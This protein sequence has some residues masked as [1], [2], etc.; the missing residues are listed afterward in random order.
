ME[1]K[2]YHL[3]GGEVICQL[4]GPVRLGIRPLK[5]MIAG[6]S[7]KWL[8]KFHNKLD[9]LWQTVLLANIIFKEMVC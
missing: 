1:E 5:Q 2:N 6:L 7:G 8:P 9:A 3:A 4:K